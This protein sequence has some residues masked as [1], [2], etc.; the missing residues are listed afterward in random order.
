VYPVPPAAGG[1]G[2]TPPQRQPD[3]PRREAAFEQ[4]VPEPQRPHVSERSAAPLYTQPVDVTDL[5]DDVDVPPF[6]KR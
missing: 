5:D 2:Y 3:A 1:T 6:M 4:Q